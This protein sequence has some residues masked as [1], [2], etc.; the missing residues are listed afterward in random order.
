MAVNVT[1]KQDE[2]ASPLRRYWREGLVLVL[3]FVAANALA[4]R[5]V[6]LQVEQREFLASQGDRRHE[7]VLP[8][9]AHRGQITD[10]NG[11]PL[12]ISV[13]VETVWANPRELSQH[14]DRLPAVAQILGMD[15]RKLIGDVQGQAERQ[16]MYVRRHLPPEVGQQVRSLRVPGLYLQREYRRFYP[17]GEVMSHVVGFTN[18]DDEAQ[19]GVERTYD[20]WLR[21]E[22]GA[23]RV[24][25][26][27]RGGVV[28]ELDMIREA[29]PGKTV[30]LS[31]DRR[32]QY[33]AYRELKVGVEENAARAGT[34]V[35]LDVRTGEVLAMVNLPSYNPNNRQ[36]IRPE[37]LRNRAM[38]DMFEPGSTMKP[39]SV[40][41]ALESGK[42]RPE[43]PIDTAPGYMKVDRF[44]IRDHHNYGLLDVTGVIRKSSNIG[45]T[46]MAMVIGKERLWDLYDRLGFGHASGLGFPGESSGRLLHFRDWSGSDIATHA[47]GYGMSVTA[48][49]LAQAYAVMANH[50]RRVPVSLLRVDVPP[51][52]E[53]VISSE[54]ADIML[55][56]MEE[57]TK[58]G[59]TGTRARV[60]GFRVAGK[61]GTARKSEAGGYA[62][63]K[64]VAVFAGV[65]PASRPRLALVV[66]IDE[67]SE[68]AYYGGQVAGPIFSR[69]MN[70]ALRLLNV[71]PDDL[72]AGQQIAHI[73]PEART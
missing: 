17:G 8:I 13:P 24:I 69:I 25:K 43:S 60:A 72:P 42:F 64:Y 39:F 29:R 61:T 26:D 19:E 35:L 54:V 59:G 63:D 56:M 67:P 65:A 57:V 12:A 3:F 15:A 16:F 22:P 45:V 52:G 31:I 48:A 1:K 53:P 40:I 62:S 66:M 6:H 9:P 34:A 20:E 50:G 30:P 33:L 73:A 10:R 36:D 38:I 47:Y 27:L 46:K 18:I 51:E 70:G 41:A 49:Q 32:L 55:R 14:L 21:G 2:Q 44:T 28:E 68:G 4:W 71:T 7:R 5:A 23:R 58:D 37:A 11:E